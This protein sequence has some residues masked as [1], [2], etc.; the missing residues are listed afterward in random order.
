MLGAVAAGA[1]RGGH[2]SFVDA[3]RAMAHLKPE[4]I[5]PNPA[6]AAAYDALY[7]DWLDLHDHFGRGGSG[8]M[9]RLRRGRG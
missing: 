9:A 6:A 8:V 3:A 1:G 4:R 7:R 2:A 5:E